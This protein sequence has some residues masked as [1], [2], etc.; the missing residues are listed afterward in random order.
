MFLSNIN[1]KINI[2]STNVLID[3]F[4]SYKKNSLIFI[5]NNY[6]HIINNTKIDLDKTNIFYKND[7]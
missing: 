6:Y 1:N 7:L 2:N 4:I 3:S 5:F